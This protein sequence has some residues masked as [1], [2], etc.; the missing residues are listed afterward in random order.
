[1]REQM[2][3]EYQMED[4]LEKKINKSSNTQQVKVEEGNSKSLFLKV[5]RAPQNHQKKNVLR[6]E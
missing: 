4:V 3:L 5:K 6:D 1:M 2:L